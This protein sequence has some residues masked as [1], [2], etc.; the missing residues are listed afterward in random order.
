MNSFSSY[1]GHVYAFT[2]ELPFSFSAEVFG[3]FLQDANN[4]KAIK[5]VINF[6]ILLIKEGDTTFP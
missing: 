6:F 5:G 3:P 2:L 1:A 4:N